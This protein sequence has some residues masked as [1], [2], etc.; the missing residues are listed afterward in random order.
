MRPKANV[1]IELSAL[2]ALFLNA[3]R[4]LGAAH[5]GASRGRNAHRPADQT[6][7]NRGRFS[8]GL[9]LAVLG[10]AI[11]FSPA[12]V[13]A[14][15]DGSKSPIALDGYDPTLFFTRGAA[16]RGK[17]ENAFEYEGA[18]YL[19]RT[20]ANKKEFAA[21]PFQY[22][23]QYDGYDAYGIFLGEVV[24]ANP[25]LWS[26]E[27]G[28]LYLFSTTDRK[29]A[30]QR[31]PD[32]HKRRANQ[33]WPS[34]EIRLARAQAL[35]EEEAGRAAAAESQN[36][37]TIF[38]ENYRAPSRHEL[39][40]QG[41]AP[42]ANAG[43]ATDS[44]LLARVYAEKY[45]PYHDLSKAVALLTF[46]TD[47]GNQAAR[48]RLGDLYADG[49]GV[50]KNRDLSFK[51][52]KEAAEHGQFDAMLRVARSYRDGVGVPPDLVKAWA[53]YNIASNRS[54]SAVHEREKLEDEMTVDE[55][56]R[57]QISTLALLSRL[58]FNSRRI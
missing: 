31:S 47:E 49:L 56:V 43:S 4:M 37:S 8:L 25:R 23:V 40:V 15:A 11:V 16:I 27:G 54:D 30:W 6:I 41:C 28:R 46:A 14:G 36:C 22:L 50:P 45:S 42:S 26:I 21:R 20:E 17:Q 44:V 34:I 18:T 57:A 5:L 35:S 12:S 51:M 32:S 24:T 19:F 52:Y 2:K 39:I 58:K 55:L 3:S 9:A 7:G 33:K 29:D 10:M 53:W 38:R 48:W 1:E 13:A